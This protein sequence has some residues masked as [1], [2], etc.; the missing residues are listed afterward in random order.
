MIQKE[1][2]RP[3]NNEKEKNRDYVLYWMQASQR[4]EYN[5][6]LE[7]AAEQANAREKPLVVFFGLT[8]KF[9]E[10]NER[11]YAFMLE[12]LKEADRTFERRG[13]RFVVRRQSPEAGAVAMARRADL[14]VVDRGY[15]RIEREWREKAAQKIDVPLIQVETNAVVPLEQTSPRDE[16]A[17]RTIRPKI[18]RQLEKYLVPMKTVPVKR[19][20]LKLDIETLSLNDP[21]RVLALLP[22][23]RS[24]G[25]VR[26]FVGGTS[27]AKKRLRAFIDDKLVLYSELRN[28][29]NTD[30]TSQLSPISI[31]QISPLQVALCSSPSAAKPKP[32]LE[33]SSSGELS[34]NFVY[35]NKQYDGSKACCI[36]GKRKGAPGGREV[37]K[38]R[39]QLEMARPTPTGT[40]LNT[41]RLIGRMPLHA[42]VLGKKII[43]WTHP[44]M[45]YS[46][47]RCGS[48]TGTSSTAVTP[49]LRRSGLVLRPARPRLAQPS[50]A[51]QGA[52]HEGIGPAAEVRC[53]RLCPEIR[54][55][56]WPR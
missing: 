40:P 4:A 55:L 32:I 24:V 43:E 22:I 1:R 49:R 21:D 23:D 30:G 11:H 51:R 50:R 36:N 7:Y 12:G 19:D 5:H 13:V 42:D 27:E 9:P 38:T 37:Q 18:K 41:M 29:P 8:E 31:S 46:R 25:R 28:D 14:V 16:F 35:Y 56:K 3:L 54:G 33:E 26:S 48:T 52:D 15:L 53:G 34:L 6:A 2:V 45:R 39:G 10:A 44:R 20:S 47:L 17:A